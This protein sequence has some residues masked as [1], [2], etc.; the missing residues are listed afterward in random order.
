MTTNSTFSVTTIGDITGTTPTSSSIY[1][2]NSGITAVAS[3]P[4]SD[5]L[6]NSLNELHAKLDQKGINKNL[7]PTLVFKFV[8]S[9]FTKLEKDRLRTRLTKLSSLLSYSKET[10]QWAMHEEVSKKIIE[11]ILEQ[12]AEVV[13]ANKIVYKKDIEK[14]V[15]SVKDKVIKFKTISEF[16]RIIPNDVKEKYKSIKEKRIFDEYW[17]LYTDYVKPSEQ[18]KSNKEKI[19]EKDPILFGKY[20]KFPEKFFWVADWQDEHCDLSLDGVVEKLENLE[21]GYRLKTVDALSKHD[22]EQLKLEIESRDQ[23]LK[24]T[25][26]TNYKDL[27]KEEDKA[28]Q[29]KVEIKV[30]EKPKE[31][32]SPIGELI[33][34]LRKFFK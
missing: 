6:R 11:V 27:M 22:V 33:K 4:S 29:E 3:P 28:R 26:V 13:G 32:V 23:R 9:K 25:K 18:I 24:D 7:S 34:Y 5:D 15:N 31:N 1:I 12:Q 16:P 20:D 19:K 10:E 17:I 2:S 21:K 14:F 30:E 8:K